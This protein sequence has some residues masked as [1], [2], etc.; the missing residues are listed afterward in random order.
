M[1]RRKNTSKIILKMEEVKHSMFER[2]STNEIIF[3]NF[4]LIF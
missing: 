4:A 1:F 2:A 3:D